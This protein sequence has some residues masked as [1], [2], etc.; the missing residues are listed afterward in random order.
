M[1]G[2]HDEDA[3]TAEHSGTV[4]RWSVDGGF[5]GAA[6][7]LGVKIFRLGAGL[8]VLYILPMIL[9]PL[10]G[11]GAG[12]FAVGA[13]GFGGGGPGAARL[14]LDDPLPDGFAPTVDMLSYF[15]SFS[16]NLYI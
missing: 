16:T 2:V 1:I 3:A 7:A 15:N 14:P 12:T 13:F 5:G 8:F 11:F 10:F 9:P 4:D 6:F